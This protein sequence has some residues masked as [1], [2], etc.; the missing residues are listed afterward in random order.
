M[1]LDLEKDGLLVGTL[2]MTEQ[3]YC[4][5]MDD[6]ALWQPRS[7]SGLHG[8]LGRT[9]VIDRIR[10]VFSGMEL[11]HISPVYRER[12]QVPAIALFSY[13]AK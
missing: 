4:V 2:R 7:L 9:V 5:E 13:G 11:D 1:K 8:H 10:P 6:G 12:G 3:G